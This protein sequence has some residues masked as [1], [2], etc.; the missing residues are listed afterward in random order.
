MRR[1]IANYLVHS[2][3]LLMTLQHYTHTALKIRLLLPDSI[4]MLPISS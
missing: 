2:R 4:F 1:D 3:P